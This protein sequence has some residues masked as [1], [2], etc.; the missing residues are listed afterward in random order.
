MNLP[1]AL[2]ITPQ[3][4]V[5]NAFLISNDSEHYPVLLHCLIREGSDALYRVHR[6]PV[7]AEAVLHFVQ[8]RAM[9]LHMPDETVDDDTL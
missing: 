7:S 6:G 4:R 3:G 2:A 1:I 9:L 8:L 5:L